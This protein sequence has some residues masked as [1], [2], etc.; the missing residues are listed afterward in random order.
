LQKACRRSIFL[1]LQDGSNDTAKESQLQ[2]RLS[3]DMH[4]ETEMADVK[5]PQ[6]L[7]PQDMLKLLVALR[8]A[9]KNRA[10]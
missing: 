9:L 5:A 3:G 7:D 4:K 2:A 6:Q 10:A 8:R 1:A